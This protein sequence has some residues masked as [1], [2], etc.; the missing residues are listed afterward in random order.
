[1][2]RTM[3]RH[4]RRW[5]GRTMAP[6][7]PSRPALPAASDRDPSAVLFVD[8]CDSTQLYDRQGDELA[9]AAI[10]L[11]LSC[12]EE[13]IRGGGGTVVKRT[14]DG[15]IATIGDGAA[16]IRMARRMRS[17]AGQ[18][19]LCIRVGGHFGMILRRDGDVYGR[20]VHL[21]ARLEALAGAQQILVT[22]AMAESLPS[23]EREQL[24]FVGRS[25]V[26]GLRQPVA[27]YEVQSDGPSLLAPGLPAMAY[28]EPFFGL[29]S[30]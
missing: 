10:D 5:L 22:E 13:E 7:K 21:A 27:L 12:F 15:L 3:T 29:E 26:R 4:A 2:L 14:G 8:I 17:L 20:T 25:A 9:F 16:A 11:L 24:R 23:S 1:M 6:D 19:G 18:W 28:A 30:A